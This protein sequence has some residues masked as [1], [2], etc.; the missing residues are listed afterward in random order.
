MNG[1]MQGSCT[2]KELVD[3]V[4]AI[5]DEMFLAGI[6]EPEIFLHVEITTSYARIAIGRETLW[7]SEDED[8][9]YIGDDNDEDGDYEPLMTCLHRRLHDYT[10]KVTEI[11]MVAKRLAAKE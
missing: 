5:H 4:E 2:L 3:A 6:E 11:T 10:M 9:E 8:R 1:P 7:D